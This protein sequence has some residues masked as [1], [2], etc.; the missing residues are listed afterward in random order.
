MNFDEIEVDKRYVLL[1][2]DDMDKTP[3]ASKLTKDQKARA[4]EVEYLVIGKGDNSKYI[5]IL[6]EAKKTGF[7][8]IMDFGRNCGALTVIDSKYH[9]KFSRYIVPENVIRLAEEE[10]VKSKPQ[11]GYNCDVCNLR[12]EYAIANISTEGIYY[13]S[14]LKRV[15]EKYVC[16]SCYQTNKW[17]YQ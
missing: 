4:I 7:W 11:N 12:N 9:D 2:D 3:F 13:S 1:A 16:W 14:D 5:Y 10:L 15:G 17:R 6:S 8:S